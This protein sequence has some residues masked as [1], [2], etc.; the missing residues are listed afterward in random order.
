MR[1]FFDPS[2]LPVTTTDIDGNIL[3]VKTN[4][5]NH[6]GYPDIIAEGFIEDGEQLILDILD[7][8]FSLEFNISSTWNYDGKLFNLE[9]GEDGLAKIRYI[10]IDQPRVI[11]IPNPITGEPTKYISKGLSELYNHPEAEVSSGLLH[12]KEILSHF[13]DQVKAGTIYDEDSII[14]CM[15]QVYEISVSYDRLGNLVLLIDQQAALP[16][17][18]I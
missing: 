1:H 9:I 5:L 7:R 10:P 8:I 2:L 12:G 6:Y 4:G 13:I 14:V 15:E 11:S 17:E 3:F 16:P 18:R